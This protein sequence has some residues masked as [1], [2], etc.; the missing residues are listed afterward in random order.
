MT[1]EMIRLC[2]ICEIYQVETDFHP[3]D[4]KDA[5]HMLN[6]DTDP[7]N[8][9]PLEIVQFGQCVPELLFVPYSGDGFNEIKSL[10]KS[11]NV[12]AAWPLALIRKSNRDKL[13][14]L[15]LGWHGRW[16]AYY[17]HSHEQRPILDTILTAKYR[18]DAVRT[19]IE[20]GGMN[21]NDSENAFFTNPKN[22][23]FIA[24]AAYIEKCR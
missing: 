10:L 13:Y 8:V 2:S 9:K 22:K 7:I 23:A 6:G 24:K 20:T 1:D 16:S 21:L 18:Y 3:K 11:M 15:E 4:E 19:M 12:R 5:N 14:R 17:H